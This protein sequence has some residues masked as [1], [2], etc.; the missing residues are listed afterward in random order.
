MGRKQSLS[1]ST[2]KKQPR[3]VIVVYTEGE[4]T[5]PAYVN[6]LKRLDHV[7][8][9]TSVFIEIASDH[10]P[11]RPR[12]RFLTTTAAVRAA[13]TLD[14]VNGKHVDATHLVPHRA[15]A[16]ERAQALRRRHELDGIAFPA[17][18]Q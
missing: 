3:R 6:A 11:A 13:Q 1:R 5:E 8:Q 15:T 4:I 12:A 7:R 16:T 2:A 10:A 17:D 18:T 14:G 9:N